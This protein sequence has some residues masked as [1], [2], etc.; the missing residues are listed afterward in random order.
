MSAPA[1]GVDALF[2]SNEPTH[3][4]RVEI[5]A[6]RC[7]EAMTLEFPTR[8]AVFVGDN[9]AGKTAVLE[10]IGAGLAG[11]RQGSGNAPHRVPEIH[12]RDRR[13]VRGTPSEA[14]RPSPLDTVSVTG[15][16]LVLDTRSD[17]AVGTWVNGFGSSV[18]LPSSHGSASQIRA[19]VKALAP[20]IVRNS[21]SPPWQTFLTQI[22]PALLYD[23][24][25]THED[26]G[27][28]GARKRDG[29]YRE[30]IQWFLEKDVEEARQVRDTRDLD[31]RHPALE[32]V[33][34]AVASMIPG[35]MIP[36]HEDLPGARNLRCRPDDNR[37]MVDLLQP[38]GAYEPVDV[39]E[40]SGGVRAMLA[41]VAD[42]AMRLLKAHPTKGTGGPA[43]VLIDEVELHLHPRWQLRVVETLLRTFPAVQFFLTTHSE[44]I[45]ASIPAEC[46]YV[47]RRGP[48]GTTVHRPPAIRGATFGEA[49]EDTMGVGLER[50][51]DAQAALDGY[52]GHVRAGHGESD[53]ARAER[54]G[55][56]ARFPGLRDALVSAD[57]EIRRRRLDRRSRS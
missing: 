13:R 8:L 30:L 1:D 11:L 40:L 19:D 16:L 57:I 21:F 9:Q 35:G 26:G 14:L 29:V 31:Y 18:P 47:L 49:L 42:L 46:L 15:P 6:F 39:A 38:D 34:A 4:A 10:A 28:E 20:Q 7:I 22:G 2:T 12:E 41:L 27:R 23:A 50:P 5:S 54:R 3:L 55:L 51:P 48:D 17:V 37:L 32:A 43:W 44:E 52:L 25:R 56:E 33:R 53:A 36:G 24:D 45:V